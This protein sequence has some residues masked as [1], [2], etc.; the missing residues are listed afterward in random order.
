MDDDDPI[1]L[2]AMLHYLYTL[3]Y[4]T[5]VCDRL[6]MMPDW[7]SGFK[8]LSRAGGSD[9]GIEDDDEALSGNSKERE[10]QV[11][12]GFDLLVFGIA[13][14]YGLEE[15][16]DMAGRVLLEKAAGLTKT[17]KDSDLLNEVD[18]F[19]GLMDGL[20]A[21]DGTSEPGV[22]LRSQIIKSTCQ[23][24][25]AHIRRERVAQLVADVPEYAVELVEMLG[26]REEE[27]KTVKKEEDRRIEKER[28]RMRHVPMNEDSDGEA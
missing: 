13:E 11:Y 15:L 22:T 10:A 3:E 19:V 6:M 27:R 2:E 20:Y 16:R 17:K 18:G 24:V 28:I 7:S 26:R 23:V 14:K 12:W 4:P 1:A 8:G 5:E 9:S 25:A 21:S